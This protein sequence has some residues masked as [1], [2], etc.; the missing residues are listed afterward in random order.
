M[1]RYIHVCMCLCC[2]SR[3]T[4]MEVPLANECSY[5]QRRLSKVVFSARYYTNTLCLG[6]SHRQHFFAWPKLVSFRVYIGCGF[7]SIIIY[8]LYSHT[9]FCACQCWLW[10]PP[11]CMLS[12]VTA[13]ST[14]DESHALY[15][16]FQVIM[17]TLCNHYT[18]P[19]IYQTHVNTTIHPTMILTWER[20]FCS[21]NH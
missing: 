18:V 20:V 3:S 16:Q 15:V 17:I 13:H 9:H 14:G 21:H 8:K 1:I 7:H 11:A 10:A 12:K 5:E 4:V 19:L 6:W 2:C